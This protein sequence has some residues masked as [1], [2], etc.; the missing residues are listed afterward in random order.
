MA[1]TA[2]GWCVDSTDIVEQAS[3]PRH[4]A[5]KL[6]CQAWRLPSA[7]LRDGRVG[8]T[9]RRL[10]LMASLS[11]PACVVLVTMLML[12]PFAHAAGTWASTCVDGEG[13]AGSGERR[14]TA[15]VVCSSRAGQRAELW[16]RAFL[17]LAIAVGP[18]GAALV[19]CA[20]SVA[21]LTRSLV[22]C[23]HA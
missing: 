9:P 8:A 16:R 18:R 11:R 19:T 12:V 15:A 7:T 4:A 14:A 10:R 5:S 13:G 21:H 20:C 22:P 17:A 6:K 3:Q 2:H 1:P 23:R